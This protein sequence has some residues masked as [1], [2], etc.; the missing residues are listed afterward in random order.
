MKARWRPHALATVGLVL[1]LALGACASSS[2][3]N[4]MRMA[5]GGDEEVRLTVENN[6]FRDA[7]IYAYWN[8]ARQRVGMVT[9]KTRE[10]F[11]MRWRSEE[12]RL[13]VDFIG[14][15]GLWSDVMDVYQ[16][17]HLNFVILP[18]S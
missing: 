12:I 3:S 7:T 17:D 16:G 8:G 9:G 2:D 10:T 6:D 15:G 14:G 1:A 5:P 13:Q 4:V 18:Q 11:E